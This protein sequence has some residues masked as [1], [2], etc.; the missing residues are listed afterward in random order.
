M[1]S[2][3]C[4]T[5]RLALHL[6]IAL[7]PFDHSV[8]TP[9]EPV[10]IKTYMLAYAPIE[11]SDQTAHQRSLIRVFDGRSMDSQGSNVSSGIRTK[12]LIRLCACTG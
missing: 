12:I 4:C 6:I 5:L 2:R 8:L 7:T 9:N 10:S 1:M 3:P 11:D